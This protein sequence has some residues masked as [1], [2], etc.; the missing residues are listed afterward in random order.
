MGG[1][2]LGA[3]AGSILISIKRLMEEEF[4]KIIGSHTLA[5]SGGDT[6]S[7]FTQ[8]RELAGG[9]HGA[10]FPPPFSQSVPFP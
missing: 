2:W 5:S 4:V 6:L 3:L 1:H 7:C 8:V 9:R 10:A